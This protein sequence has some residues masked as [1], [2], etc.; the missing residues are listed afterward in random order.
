[1]KKLT[2][3]AVVCALFATMLL[4][5]GT[6]FAAQ[7]GKHIGNPLNIG[8]QYKNFFGLTDFPGLNLF[9]LPVYYIGG[10]MDYTVTIA[11]SKQATY[12]H[13]VVLVLHKD[14]P[15]GT[16]MPGYQIDEFSGLP[17]HNRAYI[18]TLKQGDSLDLSFSI[19]SSAEPGADQTSIV[20]YRGYDL[21]STSGTNT[22]SDG[23]I[24]FEDPVGYFCPPAVN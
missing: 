24:I 14:Y 15:A 10:N 1:M 22:W 20:V 7:Q 17:Y 19:P 9:G 16:L 4:V 21:D 6:S 18:D 2:F 8:I 5:P 12:K 23:R 11:N 3:F 13:L